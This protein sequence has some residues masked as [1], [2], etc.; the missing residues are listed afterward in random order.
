MKLNRK[1]MKLAV[2]CTVSLD[3]QSDKRELMFL[4]SWW[5]QQYIY[6]GWG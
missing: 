6:K 5:M 2:L 1:K 4:N 3:R